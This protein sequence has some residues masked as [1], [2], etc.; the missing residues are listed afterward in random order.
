MCFSSTSGRNVFDQGR[1]KWRS[2]FKTRFCPLLSHGSTK[3]A[4]G[5]APSKPMHSVPGE[6]GMWPVRV[7]IVS[8]Y[9]KSRLIWSPVLISE[10]RKDRIRGVKAFAQGQHLICCIEM[11]FRGLQWPGLCLL[12][13]F[14]SPLPSPVSSLVFLA[15]YIFHP[16][17]PPPNYCPVFLKLGMRE[18]Y[19]GRFRSTDA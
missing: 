15:A 2:S 14:F 18:E 9:L 16:R 10:F 11:K 7:C 1:W 19:L 12:P 17:P 13:F 5:T 4:G 6:K 8:T 3:Q